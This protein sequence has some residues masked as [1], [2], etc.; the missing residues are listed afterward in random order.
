[1]IARFCAALCMLLL[2]ST[3]VYA[4]VATPSDLE[5]VS[6]LLDDMEELSDLEREDLLF[7]WFNSLIGGPGLASPSEFTQDVSQAS[8]ESLEDFPVLT[9]SAPALE[10]EPLAD[11]SVDAPDVNV[12]WYDCTIGGNEYQVAFPKQ[13]ASSLWVSDSGYLYNVSG[14]DVT[15]R[16]FDEDPAT[17]DTFTLLVL[18]SLFSTGSM[19]DLHEYNALA[20]LRTYYWDN[21][22]YN[23]LRYNSSWVHVQVNH[24]S[25]TLD[26]SQYGQYVMIFLL[27]GVL[28]CLWKRSPH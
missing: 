1:M 8:A 3:P 27:G 14:S 18:S 2:F 21:T 9:M 5:D 19:T 13:Y 11:G 15:G 23:R 28:I 12:V 17:D 24:V 4:A 6:D 20:E 10:V 22:S 25:D 26:T 16:V 7:D